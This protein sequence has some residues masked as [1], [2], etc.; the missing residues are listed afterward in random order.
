MI[1]DDLNTQRQKQSALTL[2]N[3]VSLV[4]GVVQQMA[5]ND[6]ANSINGSKVTTGLIESLACQ[7]ILNKKLAK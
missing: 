5:G 2:A 4:S 6:I 7:R 3:A 1:T